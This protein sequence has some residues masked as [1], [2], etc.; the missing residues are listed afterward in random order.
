MA[1]GGYKER[2]SHRRN[3][4]PF[5]GWPPNPGSSPIAVLMIRPVVVTCQTSALADCGSLAHSCGRPPNPGSSPLTVLMERPVDVHLQWVYGTTRA[6]L[7][8]PRKSLP[9]K[10]TWPLLGKAPYTTGV[11]PGHVVGSSAMNGDSGERRSGLPH[12]RVSEL[13]D[14]AGLARVYPSSSICSSHD[15]VPTCLDRPRGGGT[16]LHGVRSSAELTHRALCQ[17]RVC[18]GRGPTEERPLGAPSHP[19]LPTESW[20]VPTL[21]QWNL[22]ACSGELLRSASGHLV[23]VSPLQS[24][25]GYHSGVA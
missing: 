8:G 7:W 6:P 24:Y 2:V 14:R 25:L 20:P 15:S 10:P 12:T 5:G 23:A 1:N 21:A 19:V 18:E 9:Q 13:A 17:W 16:S 3:L 4:A 11:V 22:R